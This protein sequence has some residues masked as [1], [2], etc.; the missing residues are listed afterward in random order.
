MVARPGDRQQVALDGRADRAR[1]GTPIAAVA[2]D[3]EPVL[4]RLGQPGRAGRRRGPR[5]RGAAQLTERGAGRS[6]RPRRRPRPGQLLRVERPPGQRQQPQHPPALARA[7]RQAGDDQLVERAG[8][9]RGRQLAAGGQQLLGHERAAAGSLGD[10]QQQARR[11]PFALDPLDQGGQ[12]VAVER[13]Q[14]E[15]LERAR[16]VGDRVATAAT[17][18]SSAATTSGWSVP[19]IDQPLIARDPGQERDERAGRGVGAVQVL[20]DEDDR[21]PLARAGRAAR[22]C[23]RCVRAWRRS[24]APCRMPSTDQPPASSRARS[25]AAAGRPRRRRAEHAQRARRRAARAS[26]GPM[27]RTIGPYGSSVPA[28]QRAAAQDGHRLAQGGD[29]GRSP[30]RGSG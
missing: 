12:L 23:P 4:E 19:T 28:G 18:G 1:G 20:E 11:R 17:H 8:Q 14:R 26:A 5:R 6:C 30:R 24:G 29:P 7:D 2:L 13:R 3:E 21:A 16:R 9:R 27:A 22:G 15:P 10:E 25:R